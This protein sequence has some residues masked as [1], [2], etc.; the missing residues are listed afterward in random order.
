MVTPPLSEPEPVANDNIPLFAPSLFPVIILMSPPFNRPAPAASVT[1][2]PA[3]PLD[4]EEIITDP[5][6]PLELLDSPAAMLI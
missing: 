5:P 4:P 2:P 3:F 1:E 6:T